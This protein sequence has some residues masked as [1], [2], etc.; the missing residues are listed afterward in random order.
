[1]KRVIVS[2]MTLFFIVSFIGCG[3]NN[4]EGTNIIGGADE[5]SSTLV[6]YHLIALA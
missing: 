3:T 5:P 1:M 2:A 4:K 6:I